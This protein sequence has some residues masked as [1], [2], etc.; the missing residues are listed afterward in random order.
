M[1]PWIKN[2]QPVSVNVPLKG[3]PWAAGEMRNVESDTAVQLRQVTGFR[4]ATLDEIAAHT[5]TD[6]DFYTCAHCDR[7]YKT[8]KGR[9]DHEAAKHKDED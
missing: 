9:D 7:P 3:K 2:C 6:P 8:E 1:A 5:G 4:L